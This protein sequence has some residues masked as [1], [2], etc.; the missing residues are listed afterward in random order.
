M[1]FN[2]PC[3]WQRSPA[4]LGHMTYVIPP[5]RNE[6][7]HLGAVPTICGVGLLGGN[8]SDPSEQSTAYCAGLC[9]AGFVCGQEATTEPDPCPEGHFCPAGTSTPQQCEEGTSPTPQC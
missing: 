9:P 2:Q 8:G 5:Q 3:D 6:G 4:L 1:T 7:R